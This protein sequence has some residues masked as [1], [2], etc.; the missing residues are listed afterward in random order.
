MDDDEETVVPFHTPTLWEKCGELVYNLIKTELDLPNEGD[1]TYTD[2]NRVLEHNI[3]TLLK[4]DVSSIVGYALYYALMEESETYKI[5]HLMIRREPKLIY[6]M[7]HIAPLRNEREYI[8]YVYS[9]YRITTYLQNY[10]SEED[11]EISTINKTT[12]LRKLREYI[13]RGPYSV[14]RSLS[15]MGEDDDSS[16][17]WDSLTIDNIHTLV[18]YYRECDN[19]V[20]DDTIRERYGYVEQMIRGEYRTPDSDDSSDDDSSTTTSDSSDYMV[21]S[22]DE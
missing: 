20:S 10:F 2:E 16:F 14:L 3:K 12:C 9:I 21:D 7:T 1:I 17:N 5:N 15:I 8:S 13:C 18:K 6:D 22:R 4:E 11:T 19:N